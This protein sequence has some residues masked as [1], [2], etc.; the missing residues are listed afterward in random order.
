MVTKTGKRRRETRQP[1]P[2]LLQTYIHD[3]KRA[4][5]PSGSAR[6]GRR[7]SLVAETV[8]QIADEANMHPP[9]VPPWPSQPDDSSLQDGNG[10]GQA[11][12][13]LVLAR[14]GIVSGLLQHRKWQLSSRCHYKVL[15]E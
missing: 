15:E 7:P 6:T 5:L 12:Q 1:L 10:R 14:E 9:S 11:L 8:A 3:A 2:Y 13:T 4:S